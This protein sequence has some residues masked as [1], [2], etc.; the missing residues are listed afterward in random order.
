MV[1]TAQWRRRLRLPRHHWLLGIGGIL[2]GA[3]VFLLVAAPHVPSGGND[4]V[5]WVARGR[6]QLMCSDEMLFFAVVSLG[7]GLR[8]SLAA[9]TPRRSTRVDLATASSMVSLVALVVVLLTVGRLVYP[10]YGIGLSPDVV[11][12]LVSA[13]FGAVHLTFLAFAVT[14]A[15]L[16]W[17]VSSGPAK[18][19]VTIV[20]IAI[21]A[22]FVAGSFP[23]LTP[24]WWN[25]FVAVLLACW[26]FLIGALRRTS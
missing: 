4:L 8:G 3:A 12:L 19:P 23:W 22:A 25:L 11:A 1:D 26:G 17:F 6:T 21:V 15:A 7:A 13:T 2:T 18:W 16:T 20:G 14:T 9:R 24:T 5:H 10:A